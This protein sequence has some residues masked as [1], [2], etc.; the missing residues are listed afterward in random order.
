M[1]RRPADRGGN[2]DRQN[3]CNTSLQYCV[4]FSCS[5]SFPSA[6]SRI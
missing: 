6:Q 1:E 5:F 2:D 3:S 4:P